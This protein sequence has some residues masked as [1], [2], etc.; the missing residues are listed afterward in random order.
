MSKWIRFEELPKLKPSHKTDRWQVI[1]NEGDD[2][3]G[4]V[5]WNTGWRRYIFAPYSNCI[6]EQDCLR[7]IAEFIECQTKERKKS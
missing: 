4:E 5:Y 6:F 7:D 1:A 3:L 2:D